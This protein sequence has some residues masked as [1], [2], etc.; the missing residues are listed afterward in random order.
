MSSHPAADDLGTPFDH[1]QILTLA[2]V[3]RKLTVT[4][5]M[6]TRTGEIIDAKTAQKMGV[7]SIRPDASVRR[8]AKMNSLRKEPRAFAEFILKFRDRRCKFLV[9]LSELVSLYARMT[10][11]AT[12]HV[13]RYL[14]SLAKAGILEDD[15]A[16]NEDFMIHNPA[17]GKTA[18]KGDAFR[19]SCIFSALLIRHQGTPEAAQ[20]C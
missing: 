9:G 10:G 4:E 6:D 14:P 12:E 16:L 7:R 13:R 2:K 19:A 1:L 5:F 3:R 11:K 20:P 8:K 18:A 15:H 17:A